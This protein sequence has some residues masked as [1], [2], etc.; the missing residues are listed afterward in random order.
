MDADINANTSPEAAQAVDS[1][2]TP[3]VGEP[4]VIT[5]NAGSTLPP[6][7][8]AHA[9]INLYGPKAVRQFFDA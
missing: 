1:P 2:F 8:A 7:S 5:A 6:W 9:Y 4:A 3:A